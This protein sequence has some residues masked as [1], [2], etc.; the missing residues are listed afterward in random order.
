MQEE[1]KNGKTKFLEKKET[2][3]LQGGKNFLE[4][5]L[6]T[7]LLKVLKSNIYQNSKRFL[8]TIIFNISE[9]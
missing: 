3:L 9:K 6:K 1:V 5:F 8:K 7:F 4:I 2:I